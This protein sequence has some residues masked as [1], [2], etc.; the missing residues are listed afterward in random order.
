MFFSCWGCLLGARG[1][2]SVGFT[3]KNR[4]TNFIILASNLGPY[5]SSGQHQACVQGSVFGGEEAYNSKLQPLGTY[6]QLNHV[7]ELNQTY[8]TMDTGLPLNAQT[9][10]S[11]Y[12]ANSP[13]LRL[14]HDSS[15]RTSATS[16]GYLIFPGSSSLYW[17]T[18]MKCYRPVRHDAENS[19]ALD[20]PA[21]GSSET[22]VKI[23][24]LHGVI[25]QK[26]LLRSP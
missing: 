24:R 4:V 15:F 16:E 21:V 3:F 9:Q 11:V 10:E 25:F 18:F 20:M 17:M 8:A 26:I 12:S 23:Y 13:Q 14:Q 5:A 7:A 2:E 1:G 22:S 19:A 6:W